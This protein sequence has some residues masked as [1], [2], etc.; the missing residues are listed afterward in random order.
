M[1]YDFSQPHLVLHF[2]RV[3]ATMFLAGVL[4]PPQHLLSYFSGPPS[5]A[6]AS[7]DFLSQPFSLSL[8]TT[9][10]GGA[11]TNTYS[12]RHESEVK[13]YWSML[14][15]AVQD[16]ARDAA[17]DEQQDEVVAKLRGFLATIDDGFDVLDIPTATPQRV[18]E[19]AVV[20][21][22]EGTAA[23]AATPSSST[24]PKSRSAKKRPAAGAEP[25]ATEALWE[26]I[27]LP[28]SARKRKRKQSLAASAA[29]PEQDEAPAPQQRRPRRKTTTALEREGAEAEVEEEA[30]AG[31]EEEEEEEEDEE[32]EEEVEEEALSEPRDEETVDE[33]V[34]PSENGTRES[35]DSFTP[36]EDWKL[37]E[38]FLTRFLRLEPKYALPSVLA[39]EPRQGPESSG[40]GSH[41]PRIDGLSTILPR[42]FRRIDLTMLPRRIPK[43][44]LDSFHRPAPQCKRRLGY[45]LRKFRTPTRVAAFLLASG[46]LPRDD[47]ATLNTILD[48]EQLNQRREEKMSPKD[49]AACA[50]VLQVLT[51]NKGKQLPSVM[52]KLM[53]FEPEHIIRVFRE[54]WCRNW[55][56]YT[57][58][59]DSR[60][61]KRRRFD[62]SDNFYSVLSGPHSRAYKFLDQ[63]E[64]LAKE[65][66]DE[67]EGLLQAD[68]LMNCFHRM[69]NGGVQYDIHVVSG[70]AAAAE[71]DSWENSDGDLASGSGG[72]ETV[73]GKF[74]GLVA[75]Q[76]NRLRVR[77]EP[78]PKA[79]PPLQEP[80]EADPA[81]CPW[82]TVDG[83]VNEPFLS[84]L[85]RQVLSILTSQPGST[86]T[87]IKANI[88]NIL[89]EHCDHLL[90]RLVREGIIEAKPV[91]S[92]ATR[93]VRRNP[94]ASLA[95]FLAA[96]ATSQGS[97]PQAPESLRYWIRVDQF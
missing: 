45:L 20:A 34:L 2:R 46:G 76:L 72:A 89:G 53:A 31:V 15:R 55:L 57:P 49:L 19:P 3:I 70:D 71:A 11:P 47:I 58:T 59:V 37:L 16:V 5:G 29:P 25:D 69:A 60:G 8:Q 86:A 35:R 4:Q 21:V 44:I 90:A 82:I 91:A 81:D 79:T 13:T 56:H 87:Q 23:V 26:A 83:E 95:E 9:M 17:S 7:P 1:V 32:E 63:A 18:Q 61:R 42:D 41:V 51:D 66:G 14:S 97:S 10:G 65:E 43:T 96:V 50:R 62:L 94:S 64:D 6:D 24:K 74:T 36:S 28:P 93:A 68:Q 75:P 67:A 22:V 39:Q 12:L 92:S 48:E 40:N 80:P 78:Q 85:R 33:H 27:G 73:G 52:T 77:V 54:F 38:S 88:P 84:A 30:E